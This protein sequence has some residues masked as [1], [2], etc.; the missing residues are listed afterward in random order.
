[1]RKNQTI[2]EFIKENN[3]TAKL[4]FT[5]NP[6][7]KSEKEFF[8]DEDC[9]LTDDESKGTVYEAQDLDELIDHGE[10][11]SNVLNGVQ[12]IFY[13]S[14]GGNMRTW[15]SQEDLD[16]PIDDDNVLYELI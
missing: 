4:V 5:V 7:T 12:A 8:V 1:M 6:D 16:N 15:F 14:D 10:T 11:L 2:R 3:I 9:Y 13:A